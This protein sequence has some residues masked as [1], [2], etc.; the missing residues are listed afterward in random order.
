[1]HEATKKG[2]G[3]PFTAAR[4]IEKQ[5]SIAIECGSHDEFDQQ[6]IDRT[7]EGILN[8]L[9]YLEVIRIRT[10]QKG[11]SSNAN[12]QFYIDKL[13]IYRAPVSGFVK[14]LV[15]PEES[16][17]KGQPLYKLYPSATLGKEIVTKAKENGVVIM[18][19]DTNTVWEGD[20]VV[21]IAP[22]QNIHPL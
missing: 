3:M 6:N 12:R 11:K 15:S 18:H 4:I 5:K 14:Y 8:I 16:F 13:K 9:N 10:T 19:A 2:G 1:M 20:Y 7:V 17:S 21:E 22:K